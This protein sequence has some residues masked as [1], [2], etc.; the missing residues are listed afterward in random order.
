MKYGAKIIAGIAR[1]AAA[2]LKAGVT[3]E[4]RCDRHRSARISVPVFT[5]PDETVYFVDGYH[6]GITF[7]NWIIIP[8]GGTWKVYNWPVVAESILERLNDCPSLAAAFEID[9]HTF[10]VMAVEMPEAVKILRQ[11]LAG[12][13]LE[14][15]NGTYAQPLAGMLDGESYI[16]HFYFGRQT[17]RDVLGIDVQTFAA[18]EPS[19]FPQL[20]QILDSFGYQLVILRT[21]WAPFGADPPLQANLFWWEAP[22]GSRIRAVPRYPFMHYGDRAPAAGS[23]ENNHSPEKVSMHYGPDDPACFMGAHLRP[24][25]FSEYDSRGLQHF[26]KLAYDHSLKR[27]LLTRFEDFNVLSGAPLKGLCRLATS[28]EVRFVTPGKYLESLSAGR[29][30]AF[31][32]VEAVF[33]SD[34]FPSYYPYGLMGDVP[35]RATQ[36]AA[37]RLLEAE[38]L[39]ALAFMNCGEGI[40]KAVELEEAW[41]SLLQSQH[42][43][44]H[45]CSPWYSLSHDMPMGEVAGK[46]AAAS[47]DKAREITASSL[48]AITGA[49]LL[50]EGEAIPEKGGCVVFNSLPYRRCET[51]TV[52]LAGSLKAAVARKFF[53]EGIETAAQIVRREN[54][55][56]LICVLDLPPFA[57]KTITCGMEEGTSSEDRSHPIKVEEEVVLTNRYYHARLSLEGE[58]LLEEKA[59]GHT[60]KGGYLTVFSAGRMYDSRRQKSVL[61]KLSSGSV[62]DIYSLRGRV[63]DIDFQEEIIFYR[64]LPRVEVTVALDCREGLNFGPQKE[65]SSTGRAY[66]MQNEKKLNLNFNF[67]P[68]AA[69]LTGGTFVVEQRKIV[70]FN[71]FGFV[72][73]AGGSKKGWSLLRPGSFGCRWK[74]EQGLLQ[75]VLA[76]APGE[77]LYAS[78]DSI[79]AGGS[80]YTKLKGKHTY[81]CALHYSPTSAEELVKTSVSFAEPFLPG[82]VVQEQQQLKNCAASDFLTSSLPRP[83]ITALF[84]EEDG[85]YLRLCNYSSADKEVSFSDS[86]LLVRPVNMDLKASGEPGAELILPP[87]RIQTVQIIH[88]E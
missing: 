46:L 30:P 52:P 3:L 21:H 9:A 33:D 14:L 57:G 41:K 61:Y 35:L 79:R 56:H 78:D 64:V 20:P 50:D 15:V 84:R 39:D 44:L 74:A 59:E 28:G 26:K 31:P 68:A 60:V 75:T 12:G 72:S 70:D 36:H 77:W 7:W 65:E 16:R 5:E 55:S 27:P 42:H 85:I 13:R 40:A 63:G 8:G 19:F 76:W 17:I 11:T 81:R 6:G 25:G 29:E 1:L 37:A 66:Y 71:A 4:R 23:A 83:F 47:A 62:A 87:G 58:L 88:E 73:P 54:G 49:R 67:S 86:N 24:E 43:D 10:S 53:V 69:V 38:R 45:L 80:R 22:D 2:V 34:D 82:M 32:S 18:Q 51:I 48:A